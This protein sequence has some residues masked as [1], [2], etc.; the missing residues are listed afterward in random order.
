MLYKL[1]AQKF[2]EEVTIYDRIEDFI[3]TEG[4]AYNRLKEDPSSNGPE[5]QKKKVFICN[6]ISK[7]I[8]VPQQTIIEH[9]DRPGSYLT[10]STLS[11]YIEKMKSPTEK[12]NEQETTTDDNCSHRDKRRKRTPSDNTPKKRVVT[13]HEDVKVGLFSIDSTDLTT[14]IESMIPYSGT[15]EMFPFT[16]DI[17]MDSS[18]LVEVT[19]GDTSYF[20]GKIHYNEDFPTKSEV[21]K[22]DKSTGTLIMGR[23][24]FNP[25]IHP[26][27][28]TSAADEWIQQQ[29]N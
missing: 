21:G 20:I 11:L 3:K 29:G 5:I 14:A 25:Q 13:I 8:G 16:S 10:F 6:Y 4:A 26:N 18:T 1:L 19:I 15:Y 27:R 9:F 17:N 28:L 12:T 2:P 22:F 23:K 7:Q 24:D